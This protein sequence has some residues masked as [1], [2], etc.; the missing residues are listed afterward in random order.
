MIRRGSLIPLLGDR[1]IEI[2]ANASQGGNGHRSDSSSGESLSGSISP[3]ARAS[4][5]RF[6][7]RRELLRFDSASGQS[8]SDSIPRP[9]R[10][11][12]IRFRL[13]H[14]PLGSDSASG[15]A[16]RFDSASGKSLWIRFHVRQEPLGR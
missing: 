3:P 10:A 14:E 13:R 5:I 9:A 8:C 16:L 2:C 7:V 15:R 4:Q 11:T 12:R 6:R 1:P